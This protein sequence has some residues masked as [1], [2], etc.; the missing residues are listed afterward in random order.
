MGRSVGRGVPEWSE[1]GE[2]VHSD[3][4]GAGREAEETAPP[5]TPPPSLTPYQAG[6]DWVGRL[7]HI[8]L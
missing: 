4:V 6:V 1:H 3:S 5:P 7:R 2:R 8:S